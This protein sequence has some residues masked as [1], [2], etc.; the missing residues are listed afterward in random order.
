MPDPTDPSLAE[1][2]AEADAL[3]E[4]GGLGAAL[5]AIN[6]SVH[7]DAVTVTVN[8]HGKLV[9]L[10]LA[11]PAMQLPSADLAERISRATAEAAA[12]ALADGVQVIADVCGEHI[13]A[14]IAPRDGGTRGTE[15]GTR[16]DDEE[17][18]PQSWAIA[19]DA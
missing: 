9:G 17:L 5:A 3:P 8:L 12:A 6:R 19:W 13:A 1:L 16:G 14:A 18:T 11:E 15:R 4:H 10:V 2:L 7:D